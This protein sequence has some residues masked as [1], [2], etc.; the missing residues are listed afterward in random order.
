MLE[1]LESFLN[2]DAESI[3]IT[4]FEDIWNNY[5]LLFYVLI[6]LFVLLIYNKKI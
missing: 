1:T 3:F 4:E 5:F 6:L 2:Y